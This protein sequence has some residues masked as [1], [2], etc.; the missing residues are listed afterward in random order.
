MPRMLGLNRWDVEHAR[1][2]CRLQFEEA[3]RAPRAQSLPRRPARRRRAASR[4]KHRGPLRRPLGKQ[5]DKI[6]GIERRPVAD[7]V[8]RHPHGGK[9]VSPGTG[10]AP[11]AIQKSEIQSTDCR[12][13][14]PLDDALRIV[15][16]TSCQAPQ[17]GSAGLLPS[18]PNSVTSH[19]NVAAD[20]FA[21]WRRVCV[22]SPIRL[23]SANVAPCYSGGRPPRRAPSPCRSPGA[24]PTA[25]SRSGDR[26]GLILPW[27]V[28]GWAELVSGGCHAPDTA[29][30]ACIPIYRHAP[31]AGTG[32][33]RVLP[34]ARA[35]ELAANRPRRRS[36]GTTWRTKSS[37]TPPGGM[38]F[39]ARLRRVRRLRRDRPGRAER[40]RPPLRRATHR[41]LSPRCTA[42][43]DRRTAAPATSCMPLRHDR[44]V[45]RYRRAA[46]SSRP[47][48]TAQTISAPAARTL[49]AASESATE[50]DDM[51]VT[52]SLDGS[53]L[54]V[55]SGAA[56]QTGQ[57]ARRRVNSVDL[58]RGLVMV[59]MALD[60]TRDFFAA[61][62]M[63]PRDFAEPARVPDTLGH[64]F[65]CADLHSARRR[66]GPSPWRPRPQHA[67]D[68]PVPAD[69]RPV[70]H[71]DRAHAGALRLAVQLR[72][73]G[74]R[75]PGDL[76]D[77]RIDGGAGRAGP[78]AALGHRRRRARRDPR[79]QSP[80]RHSRRAFRHAG[81]VWAGPGASCTN[82]RCSARGSW[83]PIR[84]TRCCR[85]WG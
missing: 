34:Q 71:P 56:A 2:E 51:S 46:E 17:T 45:K 3:R 27:S 1:H 12:M 60:H 64:A 20:S 47:T 8:G 58:L 36:S 9:L 79:P 72:S 85:G 16:R 63:N 4:E 38:V 26:R 18:R 23:V 74:R 77:R 67:G 53:S 70:A 32:T 44:R 25:A 24:I 62:S 21:P 15:V 61:G 35:L 66:V 42:S 6:L 33:P 50:D 82:P 80:R 31:R 29:A 39:G 41:D 19:L 13:S 76:G 68:Q 40:P 81:W 43:C 28:R 49:G 30:P 22:V 10:T 78:S 54:P 75:I 48:F 11:R 14:C 5:S 52:H 55:Q 7:V 59:L 65:L 37:E 73:Q 69:A 84:S 83:R 57:A